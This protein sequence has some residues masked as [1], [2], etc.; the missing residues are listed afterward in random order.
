MGPGALS[1]VAQRGPSLPAQVSAA[2]ASR[3]LEGRLGHSEDLEEE[4]LVERAAVALEAR[5]EELIRGVHEDAEVAGGV[6]H[7][8][9]EQLGGH[10]LGIAG[11]GQGVLEAGEEVV[12]G[13]VFEGEANAEAGCSTS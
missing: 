12:A 7:Q 11:G 13:A 3:A 4:L 6:V 8:G 10:E 1:S 9:G 5:L 2:S